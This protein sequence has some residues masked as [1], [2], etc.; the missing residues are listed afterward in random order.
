MNPPEPTHVDEFSPAMQQA[1]RDGKATLMAHPAVI[2]QLRQCPEY[3]GIRMRASV[4]RSQNAMAAV[5]DDEE[6]SR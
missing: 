1:L 5:M 2:A 3:D 4:L 6:R